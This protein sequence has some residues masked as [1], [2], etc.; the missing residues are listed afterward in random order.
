LSYCHTPPFSPTYIG[1][2]G[3]KNM[4][5][6]I[7]GYLPNMPNMPKITFALIL[8]IKTQKFNMPIR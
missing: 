2:G 1:M 5:G 8:L 7:R 4:G 3:S 6:S